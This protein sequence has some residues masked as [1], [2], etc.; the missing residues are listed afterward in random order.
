V[1]NEEYGLF[2]HLNNILYIKDFSVLED[3]E[4]MKTYNPF[5]INRFLAIAPENL[6]FVELMNKGKIGKKTQYYF[7]LLAIPKG[8][9]FL[10]YPKKTLDKKKEKIIE[11]IMEYY[12]I[13]RTKAEKYFELLNEKQVKY[14]CDVIETTEQKIS[15]K[16]K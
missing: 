11:S 12:E 15:A 1:K 8:K 3:E 7:Y 16:S 2:N 6:F 14:I 9:K 4:K 10:K 5:M 13:N